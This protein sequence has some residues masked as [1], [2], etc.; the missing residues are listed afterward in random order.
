MYHASRVR[1]VWRGPTLR[2]VRTYTYRAGGR[3]WARFGRMRVQVIVHARRGGQLFVPESHPLYGLG[4]VVNVALDPDYGGA[5]RR[6][7]AERGAGSGGQEG[8][9]VWPYD[10]RHEACS[11]RRFERLTGLRVPPPLAVTAPPGPGDPLVVPYAFLE[12]LVVELASM[13]P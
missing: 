11:P 9:A 1:R 4:W 10:R 12:E 6:A 8:P 5:L 3:V 2:P 13:R 7:I